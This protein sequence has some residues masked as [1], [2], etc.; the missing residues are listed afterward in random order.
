MRFPALATLLAPLLLNA[1]SL[2]PWPAQVE[3]H[4]GRLAFTSKLVPQVE[5]PASARVEQAVGRWSARMA[6]KVGP[7]AWNGGK[8]STPVRI[9]F[10]AV[11]DLRDP[12]VDGSYELKIDTTGLAI[13]APT[14]IGVLHAL[15]TL[16]QC[17]EKDSSGW[18]FQALRVTDKPRFVWRG[19]LIDPC[20]H[21]MPR[22]VILRQLDGM[23]LVKLNVLH[24]HLTDDQGFRIESKTYP[25]LHEKGSNGQ[26]LSQED[27][28]RII[29]EADLRGI[30]VIPEF[31]I[32]GHATSWFQSHPELASAPGPYKPETR[33]GV[34]DP[35][36]DPTN[37][38]TYALLDRFLG[39][40]AALF[41]D[42]YVH[43]GGDENNGKQWDGNPAIQAF[44]KQTGLPDNHALQ[45]YFNQRL[46]AILKK[47]GKRMIGWDEIGEVPA[48]SALALPQDVA[49]QC[50]RGK[51]GLV[52][53]VRAGRNAVLSNGWYIDLCHSA[54]YHYLNDSLPPDNALSE[55]ERK[56]ILGGEATMWS[57]L[58]D[59]RNVD[60][61]IWPRTA[62]I[63]ERL[64]S[65]ASVKDVEDMYRRLKPVSGQLDAIGMRHKSAQ[66][67]LLRIISGSDDVRP[68]QKLVDVLEPVEGY[69]RHNL[70]THTTGTPLTGLADA[71]V[72]DPEGAR[73]IAGRVDAM[74]A[75]RSAANLAALRQALTIST[76]EPA[77]LPCCTAVATVRSALVQS[78]LG[79]AETLAGA[80]APTPEAATRFRQALAQ[81][82]G[83]FQ[84]CQ[85]ADLDA[86]H[87]LLE[88][89]DPAFK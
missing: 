14:D 68:L 1:Q 69:E 9:T 76:P 75:D 15:A 19:L 86:F 80:T 7:V 44:M 48:G 12:F 58:V 29:H 64:W 70:A 11:G 38:A 32:P 18:G 4:A 59:R 54:A 27:I 65:D 42:P 78:A 88:A 67:E 21:F 74:I 82:K 56:H 6:E 17:L 47:H 2:M 72:P 22:A 35:T 61:R 5:G 50:W 66:Q 23:E 52:N 84:E 73:H 49:I 60:S 10:N 46:Y 31:D 53:A 8:G 34:M 37:E 83:P 89:A 62:A 71:A 25:E 45:A 43:I 77:D 81:A 41:P 40:M 63:A 13:E 33:Y 79:V 85:F 20:R 55:T 51:Q 87:R 26:Y 3:K 30:R 28:R 39:E 24:L 57:E 36:F 16:Y